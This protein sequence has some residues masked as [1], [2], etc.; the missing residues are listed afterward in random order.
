MHKHSF[1]EETNFQTSFASETGE[2]SISVLVNTEKITIRRKPTSHI[3][4]GFCFTNG[5][6]TINNFNTN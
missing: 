1:F 4:F 5:V 6:K 2:I 3:Q